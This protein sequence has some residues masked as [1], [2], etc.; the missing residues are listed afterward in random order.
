MCTIALAVGLIGTG[1]SAAGSLAQGQQAQAMANMQA[2]AYEQQAQAD[3]QASAFE[4]A[5]ERK[6]QELLQ[7]NARAQ[8]GASGVALKGSPTEVLA[9]N[10]REGQLDIAAIRYGSQL[11]Q[12]AL[13]TQAAISRYGGKQAKQAS[14]INAGSNLVSGIS[15]LYDPNRAVK[16]GQSAFA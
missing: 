10:A 6:K 11:R 3:Q 13:G 1:L 8:V 12:N 14:Y 7:A 9:A 2:K 15:S 5:R 4:Q 16:F